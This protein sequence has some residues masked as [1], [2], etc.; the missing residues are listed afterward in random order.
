MARM[1]GPGRIRA[2]LAGM[3]PFMTDLAWRRADLVRL[4][5]DGAMA[6]LEIPAQREREI[7]V[8]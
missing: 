7:E 2:G 8:R 6:L 5:A 4:R 3:D 1:A